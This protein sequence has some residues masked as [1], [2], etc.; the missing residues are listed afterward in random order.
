[1]SI[2]IS[3]VK[4]IF[5]SFQEI[6]FLNKVKQLRVHTILSGKSEEYLKAYHIKIWNKEE[7]YD[8]INK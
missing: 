4:K 1:M 6:Q 8:N 5:K 3:P 2:S 7:K